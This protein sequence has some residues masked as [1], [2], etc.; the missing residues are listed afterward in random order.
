MWYDDSTARF[1]RF[2]HIAL[3][4]TLALQKTNTVS[5]DL[6]YLM[7]RYIL[8]SRFQKG[9]RGE[10]GQPQQFIVRATSFSTFSSPRNPRPSIILC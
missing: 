8:L 1:D 6:P 7:W 2:L 3:K 9:E 10:E 5:L 4:L